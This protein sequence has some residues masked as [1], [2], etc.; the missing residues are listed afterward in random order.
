MLIGSQV[1]REP[2]IL[3]AHEKTQGI[4]RSLMYERL[5]FDLPLLIRLALRFNEVVRRYDHEK[6]PFRFPRILRT[7]WPMQK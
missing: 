5:Y 4:S 2:R 3:A 6:F 1:D 7:T